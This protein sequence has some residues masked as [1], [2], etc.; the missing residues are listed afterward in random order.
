MKSVITIIGWVTLS[1]AVPSFA[2]EGHGLPGSLPPP[3]HP[4][5]KIKEAEHKGTHQ[6]GKEE[7]ELFFEVD[8]K[9]NA[10][11]IHPLTL[12]PPN[13]TSWVKLSPKTDISNVGVKIENPRTKKTEAMKPTIGDEFIE[14]PY[15]LRGSNR[16]IVY[17]TATHDNELKE[18]R[19]QIEK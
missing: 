19:V 7:K 3:I 16:F 12:M 11:K 5:G 15:D 2:H 18:A 8:Y 13:T 6:A 17:L 10:L 4:G 1:L 14:T 9:D